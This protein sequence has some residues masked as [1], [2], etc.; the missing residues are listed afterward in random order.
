[1]LKHLLLL[2]SILIS[3]LVHAQCEEAMD[4][5]KKFMN[6]GAYD[7]AIGEFSKCI[8]SDPSNLNA[9]LQRA[10]AYN[11]TKQFEKAVSDYD[12]VLEQ[13]PGM[14]NVML[15]RGTSLMKLKKYEKALNDFNQVI[16]ADEKN[17]EAFNNRGWCKKY[18]GDQE[19][20]CADWKKSKKLGNS[21]SK[22]I[23]KNEGC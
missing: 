15:S 10:T 2:S 14:T 4:D 22:I 9:F 19:G 17:E 3:L 7:E 21:E 13:R 1:M 20:A 18:L 12:K 23:L 6:K 16:A 8:D 11:I 5:G